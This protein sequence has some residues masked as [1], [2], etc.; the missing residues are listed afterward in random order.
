MVGPGGSRLADLERTTGK[1]FSL[2]GVDGVPIERC[3]VTREGS[4]AEIMAEATPVRVGDEVELELAE[5]HMFQAADAV[6]FL[7]GGFRIV[8]AG[9]GPYLGERHRLRIDHVDRHEA[10]AS[11]LD[12]QPVTEEEMLAL[13]DRRTDIHEPERRIG[14]RVDLEDRGRRRQRRPPAAAKKPAAS[15]D[16]TGPARRD[17]DDG[18][19]PS[20]SR[21][22]RRRR[23]GGT[24]IAAAD[25]GTA[26]G[27][28]E[29]DEDELE[30]GEEAVAAAATGDPP[31]PGAKKRRRGR[32]GGRRHRKPGAA[33]AAD[34]AVTEDG[35]V[36]DGAVADD[37]AAVGAVAEAGAPEIDRAAPN[38]G[39]PEAAPKPPGAGARRPRSRPRPRPRARRS[40]WPSPRRPSPRRP[41]PRRRSTCRQRRPSAAA[42]RR[43]RSRRRRQRPRPRPICPRRRP[44]KSSTIPR[45]S[46]SA[47]AASSSA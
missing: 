9:G 6:A 43:P 25:T 12:A 46:R 31:A 16:A 10:I 35:A 40:R 27:T 15:G 13:I 30:L 17:D 8:V 2:V 20:T 18:D 29:L 34:G 36:T 21:R 24:G 5:P 23:G 28:V 37:A 7:D 42:G 1:H 45:R 11:L 22:R 32:R 38:G 41:S 47:S 44:S 14:E 26:D 33:A 19:A 3:S 4:A 39:A